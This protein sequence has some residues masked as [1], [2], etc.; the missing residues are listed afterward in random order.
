[1]LLTVHDEL[2]FEC[3]ED[4]VEDLVDRVRP[5]MEHALELSVPLR[6]D[7]GSGRSWA[8]CKG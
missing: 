8:A 3:Q 1:M 7:A 2:I 6:V 5:L 4:R